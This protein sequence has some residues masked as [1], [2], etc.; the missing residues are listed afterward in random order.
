MRKVR[1]RLL[2]FNELEESDDE[3]PMPFKR[4]EMPALPVVKVTAPAVP[5]KKRESKWNKTST[6]EP[7]IE[8]NEG[9][10]PVKNI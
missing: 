6:S 10:N 2:K 4:P 9:S 3:K 1:A 5:G 7:V 8:R